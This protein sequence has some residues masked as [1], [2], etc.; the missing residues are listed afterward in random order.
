VAKENALLNRGA[1]E[2]FINERMVKR[3]GIGLRQMKELR[4]VFNIDGTEN[5][6]GTLTHYC[7]LRVKKGEKNHLQKF[8]VMNLGTDR[9]IFGYPWLE[10]FNPNVDWIMH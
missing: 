8:Y 4:R 3:L 10:T 6:H 9:A 5:K 1:T 7:L 2:N